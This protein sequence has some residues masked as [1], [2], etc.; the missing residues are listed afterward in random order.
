ML[1]RGNFR[2][3]KNAKIFMQKLIVFDQNQRFG[4]KN[5]SI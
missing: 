4:W 3:T 5:L 2:I 1:E